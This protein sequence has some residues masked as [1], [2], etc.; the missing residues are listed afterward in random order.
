[1]FKIQTPP[2]TKF[3][4]NN[5]YLHLSNTVSLNIPLKAGGSWGL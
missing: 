1:M 2:K 4:L 3:I 5:D